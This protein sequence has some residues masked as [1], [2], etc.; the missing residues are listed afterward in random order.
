MQLQDHVQSYSD[1]GLGVAVMTYDAPAVQQGFIERA[2]ISYPMLSD[3]D[4]ASVKALG[5]LNTD[6]APDH[7]AYGIPFPGVFIVD[8]DMQIRGKIF[9]D[10]YETRVSADHVLSAARTALD[11]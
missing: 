3:A 6:Y 4:A 8:P 10:G 1:A 7:R 11:L 9:I 2:G 5:I